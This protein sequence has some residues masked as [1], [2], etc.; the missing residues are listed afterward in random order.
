MET[1]KF[2]N[3]IK[4]MVVGP[5]GSV[6]TSG[7]VK[8]AAGQRTRDMISRYLTYPPSSSPGTNFQL[9]NI[10]FRLDGQTMLGTF[11]GWISGDDSGTLVS[12]RYNSATYVTS[13]AFAG[14][15]T[16]T[17]DITCKAVVMTDKTWSSIFDVGTG[18]RYYSTSLNIGVGSAS[19]IIINWGITVA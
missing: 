8:N 19:K 5:S 1:I 3:T 16:A 6:V 2:D 7:E 17:A 4:Y 14:T 15:Y 9:S 11:G 12:T 13:V 18:A 10:Y